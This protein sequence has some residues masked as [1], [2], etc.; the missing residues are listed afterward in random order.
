MTAWQLFRDVAQSWAPPPKLTVSQWA[1]AN[2]K[3]STKSSARGGQWRT[4]PYQ[5]EPMD[6]FTNPA[7][8]TIVL[9]VAIQTLKTEVMLNC[10]AYT[11]DQDPGPCL[12]VH[13][14]DTDCRKFSKI[15][16]TPMLRETPCLRDKVAEIKGT[17]SDNTIDYKEFP[18]GHMSVVASGSPGNLSA[19][20]IRYIFCD[21]IDKYPASAGNAGDPISLAQGRQEEFWNRKTMLACS[22]TEKGRSR[23]SKAYEESDK[24][25]YEIPCHHCGHFQIPDFR[26]HVKFDTSLPRHVQPKSARYACEECGGSMDDNQRFKAV[27]KGHYRATAPFNGIAGFRIS[28]LC[29]LG[30]K[31]S[32]LVNQFLSKK[33][34]PEELK[35]FVNE[36]LAELWTEPGEIVEWERLVERREDYPVGIVPRG[37]LFLTAGVDVQRGNGGRLEVE[38]VGWGENR[39]SWSVDYKKLYGDPAQAEVWEHLE[40]LLHESFPTA[41]GGELPIERMFVDSG[42]GTT[43]REVYEWV[44]K[45]PRP[46]VWAI[47]GDRRGD[48]PVSGPRATELNAQG[49]K[50][51]YGS[52]LRIINV[53]YFKAGFYADLRK[54]K[55]TEDERARGLQFPQGFCHFPKGDN[56]GD[57]HF[58]QVCN[59]QLVIHRGRNGR[60]KA[61]YRQF[62]PNEALDTRIYALGAAWDV[63]AHRFQARHWQLWKDRLTQSIRDKQRGP[64]S[65]AIAP[66]PLQRQPFRPVAGRMRY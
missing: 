14:R 58:K 43:T 19:L 50:T 62:G 28:G 63:G 37:A 64:Q 8:H 4:R 39:E 42:D 32:D 56:Y 40:S 36:Q 25:E 29:R 49:K 31:L 6:E 12:L 7:V 27:A 2:R 51:K 41:D 18:G 46:T 1:D 59:E 10:L 20:P 52:I 21:E 13:F 66:P 61:E 17:K 55:P 16:L 44:Q 26:K 15:R 9:M 38:I 22:P 48:Q 47:K 3:L 53:D 34:N 45:Q 30:T 54:R 11:I 33:D 5:R 57:E 35:Q 65:A 23:I 60:T 24:R